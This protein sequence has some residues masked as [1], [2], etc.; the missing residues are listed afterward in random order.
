MAIPKLNKQD[1]IDALKYINENGIPHHNQSSKYELVTEDGKR[2]PPKYVVGVAVH[3]ANGA[4]IETA[5]FNSVEA[6]N[7]LQGQGFHIESKQEKFQLV[8]SSDGVVST[9]ERFT[10]DNLGLGDSYKPLDAYFRKVNGEEIRRNYSKGERRNSNQTLPVRF[11]KSRLQ[12]FLLRTRS[13]FQ[14]AGII[15]IV[16]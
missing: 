15:P 8:I 3:L 1:I 2:Y 14:Y 4:K 16:N 12:R 6:K 5:S 11:S 9:D 10:M 13:L 7:Y